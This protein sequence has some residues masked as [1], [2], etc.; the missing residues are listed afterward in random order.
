MFLCDYA[1]KCPLIAM[2][3]WETVQSVVAFWYPGS[4]NTR[5]LI[6][7]DIWKLRNLDVH[8]RYHVS[9]VAQHE[10]IVGHNVSESPELC[11]VKSTMSNLP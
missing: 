6:F 3:G 10:Q 8:L 4:K 9:K 11:S 7:Y 1:E 2:E 5:A